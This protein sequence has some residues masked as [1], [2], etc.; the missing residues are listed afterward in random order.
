MEIDI[1][2]MRRGEIMAENRNVCSVANGWLS[3]Q[4]PGLLVLMLSGSVQCSSENLSPL[5]MFSFSLISGNYGKHLRSPP[6]R[7]CL[8]RWRGTAESHRVRASRC[9]IFLSLEK[10]SR[11]V[12]LEEERELAKV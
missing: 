2:L 4:C 10:G 7:R 9:D 12:Q 11:V 8:F 3:S 1:I 6:R 5:C